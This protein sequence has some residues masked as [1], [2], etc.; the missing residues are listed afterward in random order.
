MLLQSVVA[1][2]LG[3]FSSLS[4]AGLAAAFGGDRVRLDIPLIT[5]TISAGY[6]FFLQLAYR[7]GV[8]T[9]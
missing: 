9:Q 3:F 4:A 1:A 6:A 5:A 2:G 7:L 8:K